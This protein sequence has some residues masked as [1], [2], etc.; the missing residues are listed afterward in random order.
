MKLI[1]VG[2]SSLG[3]S[4]VQIAAAQATFEVIGV[5]DDVVKIGTL[6]EGVPCLGGVDQ[7]ELLQKRFDDLGVVIAIGDPRTR[8]GVHARLQQKV[9]DIK[10]QTIVHP[11]ASFLGHVQL[12]VGCIVFPGCA[13][14][15]GVVIGVACVLNANVSI[16]AGTCIEDFVTLCPGVNIGSESTLG[17]GAY[18]GMG[19][20]IAQQ[21][22]LGR[23]STLGAL[24]FAREDVATEATAVGTPARERDIE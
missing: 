13:F 11:M 14:G 18:V 7:I 20:A 21:I 1:V 2:A 6:V 16:G 12:G 9:P 3:R 5:V 22:S 4:V 24:S 10:Y 8:Q 19:A 15:P 17:T 23:W